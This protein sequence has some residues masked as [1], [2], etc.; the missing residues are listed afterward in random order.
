M[1]RLEVA[2]RFHEAYRD[3]DVAG[4]LACLAPGWFVHEADGSVSSPGDLAEITRLHAEAFPEKSLEFVHELEQGDVLAELVR[5]RF[6][7]T[8]RS[9]DLEPTGREVEFSE[10][11]FHRFSDD[12]IA[13][14]WRLTY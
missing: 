8:G 14:S 11:I 13:E 1:T 12:R 2:R 6:V 3:G 7:H 9:F 10:M 4:F 5:S